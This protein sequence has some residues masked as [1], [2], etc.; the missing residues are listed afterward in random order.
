MNE[1]TPSRTP[2]VIIVVLLLVIAAMAFKFV[3]V[4]SVEQGADGRTVVLLAPGERDF[5]L[6]EMR[7]FVAGVQQAT[8]ALA[9]DDMTAVAAAARK[10]G[11]GAAH[12]A[13]AAIV[14]KLPLEFKT[15]AFGVHRG[16]DTIALDAESL[17]DPKHTLTQLG[18]VL[19]KCVE[20][21]DRYAFKAE[22]AR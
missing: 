9:T 7:G 3:V 18:E 15:L 10:M 1:R 11:M 13:P 12:D 8:A 21:H 19:G 16:F 5:V 2:L 20:C 22:I 6:R 17:R 4:G 14:A